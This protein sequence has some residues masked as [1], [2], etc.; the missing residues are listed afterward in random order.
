[1]S[2]VWGGLFD[3]ESQLTKEWSFPH[4]THRKGTNADIDDYTD[5]KKIVNDEV[6]RTIL[7]TSQ[8]NVKAVKFHSSHYHI[9]F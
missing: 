6:F 5:D 3:C 1:M 8:V 4:E 9:T 7:N 2:L